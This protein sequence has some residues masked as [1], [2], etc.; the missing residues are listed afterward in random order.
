MKNIFLLPVFAVMAIFVQAQEFSMVEIN[1]LHG[2]EEFLWSDSSK[3]IYGG[4]EFSS[5]VEMNGLLYFTAQNGDYNYELWVTDGTQQGTHVVKEI[6]AAGSSN[7]GKLYRVG[8]KLVFA[9]SETTGPN[10]PDFDLFVSDGTQQGTFKIADTNQESSDFLSSSRVASFNNQFVFCTQDHIMSTDGTVSGT[11][12]LAPIAQYAQGFGYCEMNG[13]VYFIINQNNH[14]EVW[15]TDGTAPGTKILIDLTQANIS[16]AYAETMKA[17]N[18]KLY[19]V[20]AE[21]GQ[22]YDLYTFNGQENGIISKITLASAGNSYPTQLAVYNNALWFIA[23]NQTN[24]NLYR[25]SLGAL[26]PLPVS[27]VSHIDVSG[28]LAFANNNIYFTDNSSQTI[29]SVSAD[30]LQ[31]TE[32]ALGNKRLPWLWPN[33]STFLKGMGGKIFFIAYDSLMQQ[34]HFMISDGTTTGTYTYKPEGAH[35]LH[36]FNALL[37]CGMADVFDF[38]VYGNKV[39]VPANFNDAGRELWFYEE[40]GLINGLNE[41]GK[42]EFRIHPNPTTYRLNFTFENNDSYF[43]KS[44]EI[45]DMAGRN[46]WTQSLAGNESS[47]ELVNIPAGMYTAIVK[48][49]DNRKADQRFIV[50]K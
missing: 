50:F 25:L 7:I 6:N 20:A 44:I 40:A 48:F 11:K 45:L 1:P 33:E 12:Q 29:H 15:E 19:I 36:P 37:S 30:N 5:L 24:T 14:P 13:K 16:L 32:I 10:I 42:I 43:E 18:G 21:Q 28:S 49:E 3:H 34:Q 38:E 31:H 39:V 8:N 26:Q 9:A 23:S 41:T 35:V 46:I 4:G 22:G 27:S 47:I 17:F 2:S